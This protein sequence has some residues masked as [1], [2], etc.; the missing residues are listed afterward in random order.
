M[1]SRINTAAHHEWVFFRLKKGFLV[2]VDLVGKHLITGLIT[3][4][5]G[6]QLVFYS[7]ISLTVVGLLRTTDVN[8]LSISQLS[9]TQKEIAE[10][11]A[12]GQRFM[13]RFENLSFRLDRVAD[14]QA[15]F[16]DLVM[17]ETASLI[18]QEIIESERR[19]SSTLRRQL[20]EARVLTAQQS[21]E[22]EERIL[23][24]DGAAPA[25]AVNQANL[26]NW[27]RIKLEAQQELD[28]LQWQL[29][30]PF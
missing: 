29:T 6:V 11:V 10:L 27:N 18:E 2:M 7:W 8:V 30:E 15:R 14:E 21:I 12:G 20:L 9:V 16:S 17:E 13:A 23:S 24:G 22:R 5:M 4:V 28:L 26:E 1:V 25:T 3:L 19:Q